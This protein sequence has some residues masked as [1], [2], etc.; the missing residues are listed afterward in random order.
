VWSTHP[1]D[2]KDIFMGDYMGIAAYGGKVYGIWARTATAE[3]L[4]LNI[5]KPAES[6]NTAPDKTPAEGKATGTE[7][8][9]PA[10]LKTGRLFV[11]VGL[12]D[13]SRNAGAGKSQS[14]SDA[15]H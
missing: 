3:E 2:P 15:S 7:E 9:Q 10:G 5:A 14:R 13:F 12:A 8:W 4:S 1:S 6:Q 11:E